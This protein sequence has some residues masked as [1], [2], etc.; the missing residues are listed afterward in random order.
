MN[1]RQRRVLVLGLIAFAICGLCPPFE[2][3]GMFSYPIWQAG[4]YPMKDFILRVNWPILLI[5]W[6]VTAAITGA[7]FLA[8]GD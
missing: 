5:V 4:T 8:T 3:V 6:L 7:L 2:Y 1:R